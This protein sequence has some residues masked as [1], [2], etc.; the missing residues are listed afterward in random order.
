MTPEV[1]GPVVIQVLLIPLPLPLPHRFLRRLILLL[2]EKS[3][4]PA[5]GKSA[6][7]QYITTSVRGNR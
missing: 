2:P 5:S 4:G 6:G 3:P 7:E 1:G